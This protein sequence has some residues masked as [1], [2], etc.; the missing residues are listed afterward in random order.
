M[1]RQASDTLRVAVV[2]LSSG[3]DVPE[4]L[5]RVAELTEE[6]VS[7][8]A[9]LVVLPENAAY[10][11]ANDDRAHVAERVGH[12][13]PILDALAALARAEGVTLVC[14]GLP[15]VGPE[16]GRSY[17]TAVVFGPDG[18]VRATYRKIHLFDVDIDDGAT[19]RESE[20]TA[21]GDELAVVEVGGFK[22]GLSICYDIRFPEL[23]RHY[24]DQ[25]VDAIIVGAAFTLRT[26]KD[27]WHALLRARA[28]ENTVYVV[29]AA[30][31]G[32]HP[33]GRSTYGKSLVVDPWGDVIAQA[34][35]GEG[36]AMATL[37]RE[38]LAAVRR[39]IPSVRNRR[40]GCPA[41]TR[42]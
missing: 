34:S 9:E 7:A 13:G 3:P 18:H 29:A 11:G 2:Q 1:S 26:G 19:Y 36:W 22:L 32:D 33:G 39:A 30:Q 41:P 12:R 38:R 6:A 14:A 23:Y 25:G 5:A 24:A 35:E 8:G 31:W 28:I 20:K 4:N 40:M 16:R 15:E 27:H 10:F 37:R 21:P 42:D 17:N